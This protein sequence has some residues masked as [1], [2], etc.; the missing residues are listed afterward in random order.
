MS[1]DVMLT[2]VNWYVHG[3]ESVPSSPGGVNSAVQGARPGKSIALR[4]LRRRMGD[5]MVSIF[6]LRLQG[7]LRDYM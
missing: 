1:P 7:L 6:F 2:D 4:M 5:A 3:F